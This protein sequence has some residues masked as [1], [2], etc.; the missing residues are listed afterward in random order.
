[1]G[2]YPRYC[3]PICGVIIKHKQDLISDEEWDNIDE[4]YCIGLVLSQCCKC[5]IKLININKMSR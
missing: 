1:M 2:K 5:N 3:C 4:E